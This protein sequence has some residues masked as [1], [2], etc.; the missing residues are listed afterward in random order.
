MRHGSDPFPLPRRRN[1]WMRRVVSCRDGELIGRRTVA[2]SRAEQGTPGGSDRWPSFW[3]PRNCS[4]WSR[5]G[6]EDP[7]VPS[8]KEQGKRKENPDS[9]PIVPCSLECLPHPPH[10]TLPLGK[11]RCKSAFGY[12]AREGGG[13]V[14]LRSQQD[15]DQTI[16]ILHM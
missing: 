6:Y 16:K 2:R 9:A 10:H 13:G 8:N 1:V 15:S 5:R 3:W 4:R 12:Y 11:E 7:F 14:P